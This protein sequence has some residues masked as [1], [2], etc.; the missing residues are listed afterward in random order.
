LARQAREALRTRDYV[1]LGM[2][3]NE[4]F[5]TRKSIYQLPAAQVQMVDIARSTGA[6][7]KFAGSG[8]AI[9]GTYQDEAMF[10]RLQK[11]LNDIRCVVIKPV[12]AEIDDPATSRP[13]GLAP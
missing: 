12:I 2:L 7:A 9:L 3:M 10:H 8:G 1:Q 4:N 13:V 5:D 11:V 6:S